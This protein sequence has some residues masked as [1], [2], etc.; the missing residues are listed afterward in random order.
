M[1]LPTELFN[2]IWYFCVY[3][4]MALPLTLSYRVSKILNFAHGIYITLGAYAA[5]LIAAGLGT[6]I[7]PLIAIP[8]SFFIG[9]LIAVLVHWLAFSP[10]IKRNSS[11]VT[12]MIASMGIWIFIKYAFYAIID[13]LQ[14][15]WLTSLFYTTPNID[16]Q[17]ELSLLGVDVSA[18]FMF[19]LG[20]TLIIFCLLAF[21]LTKTKTGMAIRAVADNPD[22]AQISGISRDKIMLVTW[23]ISGGLAGIAGFTWS[24]FTYVS[25]EAG[26]VMILPVFAC[27]VIG[28][29]TS[30]PLTLLGAGVIS[31]AENVLIVILYRFAG[32]GLSFRPFFSFFTLLAAILIRPPLGAGGGLPYR[33]KLRDLL[34]RR[35]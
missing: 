1:E 27:S 24:L 10:L 22:L 20:M 26:D 31:S 34:R 7:S 23:I 28:G 16:L 29:L 13:V 6:K 32:V 2:T 25:L 33:Y 30:L 8:A 9:S 17:G 3:S 19:V 15:A 5:I 14:K 18:R 35:P 11:L 12:L 4:L 21:F